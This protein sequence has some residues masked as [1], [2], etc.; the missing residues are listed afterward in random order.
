MGDVLDASEK[1][2]YFI[3]IYC[4]NDCK[5]DEADILA[6]AIRETPSFIVLRNNE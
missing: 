4:K 6:A 1:F 3:V 5:L 2:T